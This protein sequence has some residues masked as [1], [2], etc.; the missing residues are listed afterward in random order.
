MAVT[1]KFV[2]G[3]AAVASVAVARAPAKASTIVEDVLVR[4]RRR[5]VSPLSRPWTG[6]MVAPSPCKG[7]LT[8]ACRRHHS[9]RRVAMMK[10][11]SVAV[12]V[13]EVGLVADAA[14]H[15]LALERNA[16]S[17][18]LGA[19][20]LDVLDVERDCSRARLELAADLGDVD[21][22]DRE[23]AGLELASERVVVALGALEAEHAAVE[24]LRL[25]EARDRKEDEVGAGDEGLLFGHGEPFLSLPGEP[26]SYAPL[27]S[28]SFNFC[29]FLGISACACRRTTS[30]TSSLPIPCPSKSSSNVTRERSPSASGSTV[31]LTFPR[32][33]PSIP[34]RLQLFGG[35]SSVTSLVIVRSVRP[36]RRVTTTREPT[37]RG[38]SPR[39]DTALS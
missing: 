8:S 10:D 29:M 6:A 17:F 22:L 20:A 32:T 25:L 34:R 37:V 21:D 36:T 9:R 30:G 26:G 7:Q 33:G 31:P 1:L 11:Q 15:R 13:L 3:P 38:V 14:V 2:I 35:S 19:G 24:R 28:R 5:I 39:A 4:N 12:L 18:E 27:S 16:V 23:A